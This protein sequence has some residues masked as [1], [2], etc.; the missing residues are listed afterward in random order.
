MECCANSMGSPG[1]LLIFNLSHWYAK[2][3]IKEHNSSI[4]S[5]LKY[6][7]S[8]QSTLVLISYHIVFFIMSPENGCTHNLTKQHP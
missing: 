1:V 4:S 2:E 7:L 6:M 8:P 5:H 3:K